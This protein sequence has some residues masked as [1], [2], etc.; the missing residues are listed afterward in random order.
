MTSGRYRACQAENGNDFIAAACI[1]TYP[2]PWVPRRFYIGSSTLGECIQ[3]LLHPPYS[4]M[5]F[6]LP[7]YNQLSNEHVGR[8]EN[9]FT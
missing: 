2:T 5:V 4:F 7:L 3:L 1:V 6:L 9:P 8:V